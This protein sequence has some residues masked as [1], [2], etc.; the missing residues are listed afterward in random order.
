MQLLFSARETIA[1]LVKY[2]CKTFITS[3]PACMSLCKWDIRIAWANW[4]W[5]HN[6]FLVSFF[7]IIYRV[8]KTNL[9]DWRRSARWL[10]IFEVFEQI[11]YRHK[12]IF[13]IV[14]T[15]CHKYLVSISHGIDLWQMLWSLRDRGFDVVAVALGRISSSVFPYQS[16]W[17]WNLISINV[18]NRSGRVR[19]KYMQSHIVRVE[20]K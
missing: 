19:G 9:G 1:T 5:L 11:V 10:S 3:T 20:V 4:T 2:K 7:S 13:D 18:I 6:V 8:C 12:D 17:V 16:K 14:N 15:Y